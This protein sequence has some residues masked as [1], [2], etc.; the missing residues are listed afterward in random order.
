[1]SRIIRLLFFIGF[2]LSFTCQSQSFDIYTYHTDPPFLLSD[3]RMDLSRAWVNHFN[4]RHKD[5]KL[6][7]ITIERP[8]LNKLIEAKHPYL[9]LWANPI[10]FKSRDSAVIASD[11]IFWDS[12]IWISRSDGKV[13]Y[14]TPEDLIGLTIGGR[15]GYYYKGVNPLVDE[16]KINRIDQN[17]D[18]ANYEMLLKG[19]VKAF[20][21][22]R[23]SFL[24]WQS[25][26]VKTQQL[27]TA[28]S[29]HDAFTRHVLVS[30]QRKHL[31]PILNDFIEAMKDDPQ[32]QNQ[33]TNWGVEDLVNPFDIE[34]DELDTLKL[35]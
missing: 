30:Q 34:L 17:R 1:M 8:R 26:G 22:S 3:Q 9:I 12:D 31:L 21:M 4:A 14:S 15:K 13:A 19:D 24:Y 6:N 29:A 10:W 33:L 2:S 35:N 11:P 32:W 23:S 16:G 7:L 28:M 5:V 18:Y 25:T 27:Y 20:V